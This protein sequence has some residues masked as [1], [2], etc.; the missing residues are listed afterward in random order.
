MIKLKNGSPSARKNFWIEAIA[1][2]VVFVARPE[3]VAMVPIR[4][5]TTRIGIH[6]IPILPV[7]T[8]P[9]CPLTSHPLWVPRLLRKVLR[10][11]LLRHHV[12][13]LTKVVSDVTNVKNWDTSFENAQMV[14]WPSKS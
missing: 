3:A 1:D 2:L 8:M 9:M 14:L 4:L 7:I 10:R 13:L 11:P 5:A 6:L 12:R